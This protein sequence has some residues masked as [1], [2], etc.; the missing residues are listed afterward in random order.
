MLRPPHDMLPVAFGVC[1]CFPQPVSSSPVEL[2]YHLLEVSIVT[3]CFTQRCILS[4]GSVEVHL[5]DGNSFYPRVELRFHVPLKPNSETLSA[6]R[7][8]HLRL[9]N[10]WEA[11]DMDY[12]EERRVE[13][14]RLG[15][16]SSSI[17]HSED[18]MSPLGF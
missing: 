9:S 6:F 8:R 5:C 11:W 16:T 2:S 7:F 10:L 12:Y 1:R 15:S 17:F 3:T 14:I 18:R 13:K 4:K